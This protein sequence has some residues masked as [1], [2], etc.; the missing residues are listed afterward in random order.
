ALALAVVL[1]S[2][3]LDRGAEARMRTAH[4]L[5]SEQSW[6]LLHG[7]EAWAMRMLQEEQAQQPGVDSNRDLWAQPLPPIDVPGGRVGGSMRELGGCLNLNGL[8][9]GDPRHAVAQE[10]LR[11]LLRALR[12]DENIAAA[13]RDWIDADGDPST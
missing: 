9:E 8:G 4:A 12:L 3:L 10:R 13:V 11:N 1:V 6:Q 5:R 7:L 2:A